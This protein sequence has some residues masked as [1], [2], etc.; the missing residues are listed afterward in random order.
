MLPF[1]TG[2][3]ADWLAGWPRASWTENGNARAKQNK[4]ASQRRPLIEWPIEESGS[5]RRVN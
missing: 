4:F 2:K 1:D 5:G 3:L